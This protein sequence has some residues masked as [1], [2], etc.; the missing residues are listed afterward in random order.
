MATEDLI[1][2][3][4]IGKRFGPVTVLEEVHFDIRAGEVHILA[5]ENGAGKST[6]I[7]IL[8]GIYQDFEGTV[9]KPGSADIR[10]AVIHQEL[11]LI[12]PM[13]VADNIFL[14]RSPTRAGFVQDAKQRE[15]ASQWVQQFGLE[16]DVTRPVEEFPIAVQQLIEIAKALSQNA[17]VMVMDEPTSALNAPEVQRL[18]DLIDTL[19][20]RGCGIVYISHKMDEIERIAD[21]ITVLRDGRLVGSAPARELPQAKLISW[22]VGRELSEQFPRRAPA[23][24]GERLRLENFTVPGAAQ[25]ISLTVRAGEV[26]G[27]AGL[28]GSGA[29]EL[30]LGLFGAYGDV[31]TGQAWLDGQEK[32]FTSPQRAIASGLGL[33]TND[34]KATGLVLSLSIIANATLAGLRALS[35]GGWRRPG[36]ERVAAEKTTAPMKLRASSLDLEVAA[37]SGGNQQ[38]VALAKWL[39]IQPRVLLLDEPTRGIDIAAKREIYQLIDELTG[40][41]IAVLLITSEMP[42][43]LTLSD[44]IVVLHRGRIAAQFSRE[45]AAPEKI[46]AAAMGAAA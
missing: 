35:P 12:G 17:R 45:E 22:M 28:Q 11:S 10:V 4:G 27:L 30:L 38:K 32:R 18:F 34:R 31:T 7:K 29:S 25:N 8:G 9:E 41:G 15:E 46:L 1:R 24:G 2:M 21:H 6:L 43:L 23:L 37:L 19:K 3:R 36:A 33:L 16:I 13:S 42:E 39:Q 5:G 26:V 14:G 20:Q 40:Q 44:R